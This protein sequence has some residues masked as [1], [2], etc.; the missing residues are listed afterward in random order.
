MAAVLLAGAGAAALAL[1]A[2]R[3]LAV[4]EV[5][6][7]SM[8]PTML[9][10]DRLLAVRLPRLARRGRCVILREEVPTPEREMMVVKR[11]MAM[12]G[13]PVPPGVRRFPGDGGGN[14]VPPGKVVVFG[15]GTHSTDSR[16]YGFVAESKIAAVVVTKLSGAR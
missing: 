12:G 6:G 4:V 2:R 8:V 16:Q 15:D 7:E 5:V 14:R 3:G 13:D 1:A 11:L 9:P 10:G